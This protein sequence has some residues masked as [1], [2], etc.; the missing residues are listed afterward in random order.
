ML[1]ALGIG[2][3]ERKTVAVVNEL[4][5]TRWNVH[6]AYLDRRIPLLKTIAPGVSV[7]YLNRG[8][9]KLSVSAVK[10]LRD[11]VVSKRIATIVC[12]NQYPLLY[13]KLACCLMPAKRRPKILLSVNS[14]EHINRKEDRQMVFYRTLI[15]RVEQIVFGCEAQ[16]KLWIERYRLDAPRC[17]VIYNGIDADRYRPTDTRKPVAEGSYLESLEDTDFVIGAI[18]TLWPNKNHIEIILAVDGIRDFLPSAKLLIAGEGSERE[19]LKNA[20]ARLGLE[21]RVV[22]LGEIEDI[23]PL[24]ERIDVFVLPSITETFSNAALEAMSMEKPVI[25]SRTG[26]L[27]EMVTDGIDG[28]LYHQGDVGQ[29]ATLIGNIAK[30]P[31]LARRIGEAARVTVLTRF[32]FGRMADDYRRL[33]A[34]VHDGIPA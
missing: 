33:L 29:L 12:I 5:R 30:D 8:G 6:L 28:Y 14:T 20:V 24:L 3:S 31:N 18:G 2:G 32:T 13:A 19:R 7:L 10:R 1:N 17:T 25:L 15:R 26:G 22:L 16:R 21:N 27:P 34:G 4:H 11:Y 9:K 23:R